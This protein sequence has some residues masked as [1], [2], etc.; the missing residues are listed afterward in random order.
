MSSAE[1]Q[2]INLRVTVPANAEADATDDVRVDGAVTRITVHFPAGA[3]ALVD[4]AVKVG[5]EQILPIEGFIALDNVTPSFDVF[6]P[7]KEGDTVGAKI[8]NADG[9]NPH[10]ITVIAEV[11]PEDRLGKR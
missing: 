9:A 7:V 4:V 6:R 3:N 5:N 11:T 8:R 1:P 10:T 2:I